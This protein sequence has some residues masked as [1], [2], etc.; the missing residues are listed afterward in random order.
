MAKATPQRHAN[1]PKKRL[2]IAIKR[3]DV[4]K[5]IAGRDKGKTGRVL[6]VDREKGKVLVE[7]ISMVKRHTRPNPAKQIKGGIAERE[8]PIDVSNVMIMNSRGEATR[9]GYRIEGSGASARR[10][11]FAK[12]GGEVLDKKG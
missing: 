10:V 7:G 6:H 3:D 1:A 5:V 4:V 11:R 2:K 12:K 8:S 9:I